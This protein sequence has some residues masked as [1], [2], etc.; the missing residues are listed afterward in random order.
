MAVLTTSTTID[1]PFI[2]LVRGLIQGARYDQNQRY[3]P[4]FFDCSSLIH[5]ALRKSGYKNLPNWMTTATMPTDLPKAGFTYNKREKGIDLAEL[6]PGDILH[7]PGHTEIFA[8]Y[9]KTG[10]PVTIGAHGSKNGVSEYTY[11]N[12]LAQYTGYFRAPNMPMSTPT[13]PPVNPTGSIPVS[14][15]TMIASE[16]HEPAPN[17]TWLGNGYGMNNNNNLTAKL[18]AGLFNNMPYVPEITKQAFNLAYG[19]G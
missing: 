1:N 12:I 15:P 4:G 3:S 8:G 14:N 16:Q 7:R 17:Q 10:R 2:N 6:R 19:V 11:P 9:D 18:M 5:T 13:T